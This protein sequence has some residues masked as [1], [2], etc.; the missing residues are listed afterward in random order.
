MRFSATV[1][2]TNLARPRKLSPWKHYGTT[3]VMVWYRNAQ[4]VVS[5][6]ITFRL[7]EGS[8]VW[9]SGRSTTPLS[10]A[11]F[12]LTFWD[13]VSTL[14]SKDRK[15]E[16]AIFK[17]K[18]FGKQCGH[19][20]DTRNMRAVPETTTSGLSPVDLNPDDQEE[21]HRVEL[22]FQNLKQRQVFEALFEELASS[23]SEDPPRLM[24]RTSLVIGSLIP[25]T[26]MGR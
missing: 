3:D 22:H 8:N 1:V 26:P 11:I 4:D 14:S 9:M 10:P 13:V 15:S 25:G 23:I 12:L 21:K 6:S 19:V 5:A 18:M 17:F 7:S 2:Q 20:L 24:T 16:E